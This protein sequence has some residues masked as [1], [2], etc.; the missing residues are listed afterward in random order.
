MTSKRTTPKPLT[1]MA[2]VDRIEQA[3]QALRDGKAVDPAAV[4][5]L[6]D[7]FATCWRPPSEVRHYP[8]RAQMQ[9][10]VIRLAD[11]ILEDDRG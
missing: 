3:A 8:V 6:L 10:V 2:A 9:D 11:T 7:F 1:Y 4:A 5:E